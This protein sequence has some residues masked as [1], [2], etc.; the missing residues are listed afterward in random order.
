[1]FLV[2]P[3]E[4]IISPFVVLRLKLWLRRCRRRWTW[5]RPFSFNKPRTERWFRSRC[6][7]LEKPSHAFINNDIRRERRGEGETDERGHSNSQPKPLLS[8]NNYWLNP[9]KTN[10]I[11]HLETTGCFPPITVTVCLVTYK[12]WLASALAHQI[13]LALN[14][15]ETN[16]RRFPPQSIWNTSY[17]RKKH[18]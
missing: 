12:Q 7:A 1:M 15:T 8:V 2:A 18:A 9:S 4:T 11:C 6:P 17:A 13:T 3:N 5:R 16:G 10:A 14:K